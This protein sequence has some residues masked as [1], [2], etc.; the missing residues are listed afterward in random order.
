MTCLMQTPTVI[1][2]PGRAIPAGLMSHSAK[3]VSGGAPDN[4]DTLSI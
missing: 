3:A 1:K 4:Q 2:P